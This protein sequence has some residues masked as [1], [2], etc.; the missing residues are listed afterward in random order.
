MF[1][2]FSRLDL[3]TLHLLGSAAVSAVL[4]R[5]ARSTGGS[6]GPA[7]PVH[8]FLI[9][10]DAAVRDSLAA[11]LE[12]AG[13]VVQAYPSAKAFIGDFHNVEPACVVLDLDLPETDMH[14]LSRRLGQEPCRVPV[15]TTSGQLRMETRHRP[16]LA[17]APPPLQK[18]FGDMQLIEVIMRA[19]EK[20][21]LSP[22]SSTK[23]SQAT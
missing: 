8:V 1:S 12:A 15:V 2:T 18:P 6:A 10:H 4:S 9:E 16:Y 17:G 7:G 21:H 11:S 14:M 20:S 19:V 3:P 22:L 23:S 5:S 13:L